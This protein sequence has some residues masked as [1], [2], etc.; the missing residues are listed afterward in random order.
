CRGG[1]REEFVGKPSGSR[2]AH[3][4]AVSVQHCSQRK[5]KRAATIQHLGIESVLPE[6]IQPAEVDGL[7]AP[8]KESSDVT[9][10]LIRRRQIEKA[11]DLTLLLNRLPHLPVS[12]GRLWLS[13]VLQSERGIFPIGMDRD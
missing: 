9:Q 6:V 8:V 4:G 5:R 3:S 2:G 7:R 13:L 11:P 1:R 12:I 10:E